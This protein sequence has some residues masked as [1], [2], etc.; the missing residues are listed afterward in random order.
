MKGISNFSIIAVV[1]VIALVVG[2]TVS[3]QVLILDACLY[4]TVCV[5][6]IPTSGPPSPPTDLCYGMPILEDGWTESLRCMGPTGDALEPETYLFKTSDDPV[7]VFVEK[8]KLVP[9]LMGTVQVYDIVEDIFIIPCKPA[10]ATNP[11]GENFPLSS[12]PPLLILDD[13]TF[14]PI[15]VDFQE[16]PV[17]VL[18]A[19][20]VPLQ[21]FVGFFGPG[22]PIHLDWFACADIDSNGSFYG[23]APSPDLDGNGCP[24]SCLEVL[25][26]GLFLPRKGLDEKGAGLMNF[27][28]NWS[29]LGLTAVDVFEPQPSSYIPPLLPGMSVGESHNTRPWC[30]TI[31]V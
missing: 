4:P 27:L 24:D 25:V 22:L 18:C 13:V 20:Q 11:L 17:E 14:P 19:V 10:S 16:G 30:F 5:R 15:T 1:F 6:L 7:V 9:D 21:L 12:I 28:L 23:Q 3:A 31:D 26:P 2:P 8:I 29:T